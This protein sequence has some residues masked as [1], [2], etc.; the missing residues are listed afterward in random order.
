[1]QP[2]A[3]LFV[4]DLHLSPDAPA[5]A[6]RFLSF[7]S[8][9]ARTAGSLTILGDLFDYWAGDD[10]LADPFNTR[11]IGAL[12]NLSDAGVTIFFMAGNRDLL[13]GAGFA[14]VAGLTLLPDPCIRNIHGVKTLLSHGDTLCTDD[15]DYQRFRCMVRDPA[16]QTRFLARPLSER[17]A[18]IAALRQ[19]SQDEKK[20]KP[21][22]IMDVNPDSVIAILR[23]Y[24][25]QALIHGHTHRQGQ[26]THLVDSRACQ[27]WVLGD[28]H[29]DRGETLSCDA[30]GWHFIT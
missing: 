11:I 12:R 18:E 29:A 4:S 24:A 8:G 5:T 17:K 10:D 3:A 16:W 9:T 28:W 14:D 25:A 7:L 1:M 15:A 2:G 19:R 13:I 20:V 22:A 6:A 30:N 23:Q 21:L 27:R 26:H